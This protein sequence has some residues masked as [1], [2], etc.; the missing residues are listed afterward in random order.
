MQYGTLQRPGHVGPGALYPS[1]RHTDMISRYKGLR[2]TDTHRSEALPDRRLCEKPCKVYRDACPLAC[3]WYKRTNRLE[4]AQPTSCPVCPP[5][6]STN[7]KA[8]ML[9]SARH[10]TSRRNQALYSKLRLLRCST[11]QQSRKAHIRALA[12]KRKACS[13]WARSHGRHAGAQIQDSSTAMN[14]IRGQ[15]AAKLVHRKCY[16]GKH[17]Q[18]GAY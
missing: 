7:R 5:R 14:D 9:V 15:G 8:V 17:R 16:A 12:Q 11:V 3:R 1:S 13:A 2:Q 4:S 6:C 10:L 18:R